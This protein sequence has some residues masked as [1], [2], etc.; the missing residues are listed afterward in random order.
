M[1]NFKDVA[2]EKVIE[3]CLDGLYTDGGHHK[4]WYLERILQILEDKKTIKLL[5]SQWEKG[6]AP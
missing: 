4:Q 2:I 1:K 3:L 5:E 6:I